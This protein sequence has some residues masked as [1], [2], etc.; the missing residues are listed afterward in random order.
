MKQKLI[1]ID[2]KVEII[3]DR[4]DVVWAMDKEYRLT[5]FNLSFRE[6]LKDDGYGDPQ[7]GMDLKEI[8]QSGRFFNPCMRLRLEYIF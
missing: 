2:N 8:Y 3:E 4:D 1:L 5:A 6:K 7:R